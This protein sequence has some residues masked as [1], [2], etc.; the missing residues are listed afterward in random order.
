MLLGWW[1]ENASVN[2]WIRQHCKS[3]WAS[4]RYHDGRYIVSKLMMTEELGMDERRGEGTQRSR[5]SV[6][7]RWSRLGS[8]MQPASAAFTTVDGNL[9]LFCSV[10]WDQSGG[11]S[12]KQTWIGTFIT[13]QIDSLPTPSTHTSTWEDF[14]ENC[15]AADWRRAEDYIIAAS[16]ASTWYPPPR[17]GVMRYL[18][19]N[20]DWCS[21]RPTASVWPLNLVMQMCIT[22][23]H[24]RINPGWY[25]RCYF[26]ASI[27]HDY[28][29]CRTK[30][31]V[32]RFI[33]HLYEHLVCGSIRI[34][35]VHFLPSLVSEKFLSCLCKE[36]CSP[37]EPIQ[38]SSARTNVSRDNCRS[39][40]VAVVAFGA[41]PLTPPHFLLLCV[42]KECHSS[43]LNLLV[44]RNL[45]T[46][47]RLATSQCG[48]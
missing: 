24:N 14:K 6:R 23:L 13:A 42:S 41:R 33:S 16:S 37:R 11:I 48:A 45:T 9:P 44:L 1:S 43:S 34:D 31:L 46:A 15:E 4:L 12:S 26:C 17:K 19:P 40:D 25:P 18:Q 22:L 8:V 7:N 29:S 32:Q 28:F 47:H 27:L 3:L 20:P 5:V 2:E 30:H 36:T 38:A 35:S 10:I 39:Q 21:D